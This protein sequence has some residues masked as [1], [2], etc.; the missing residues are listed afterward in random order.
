MPRS[1]VA[2]PVGP[3]LLHAE[4]STGHP[5]QDQ[6]LPSGHGDPCRAQSLTEESHPCAM[7][8]RFVFA[9]GRGRLSREIG[10]GSVSGQGGAAL[11]GSL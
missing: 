5:A 3:R 6:L 11:G 7:Y 9:G 4:V 8:D 2:F 10:V 1:E